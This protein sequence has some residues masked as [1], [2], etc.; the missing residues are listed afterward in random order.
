MCSE[1]CSLSKPTYI[2]A[3]T[4]FLAPKH[5]RFVNSLIKNNYA[6]LL[7]DMTENKTMDKFRRRLNTTRSII[8]RISKFIN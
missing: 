6:G 3:P 2:F 7:G 5:Q 4:G 1:L 8:D